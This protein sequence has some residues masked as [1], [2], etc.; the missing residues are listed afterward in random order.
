MHSVHEFVWGKAFSFVAA[1]YDAANA[2]HFKG[3]WGTALATGDVKLVKDGVLLGT[4][5]DNLTT[6]PTVIANGDG[7]ALLV[8]LSATEAEIEFGAIKF[9]NTTT[10]EWFDILVGLRAKNNGIIRRFVA[11]SY[12]TT[13]FTLDS[14]Y[15]TGTTDVFKGKLVRVVK[16]SS[17]LD[18]ERYITAYDATT[19]VAT[20]DPPWALT[21]TVTLE[22]MSGAPAPTTSPIGVQVLDVASGARS[23]ISN[24]V[25][26]DAALIIK[27]I[28]RDTNTHMSIPNSTGTVSV[29]M[30]TDPTYEPSKANS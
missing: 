30:T 13:S 20:I 23:Q 16:A 12:N 2:M 14:G 21:G 28:N 19:K 11:A 3:T 25:N 10:N 24:K 7:C 17:G 4:S 6:L 9:R 27:G 22:I 26:D 5:A 18:V 1:V 15:G 8:S 29:N